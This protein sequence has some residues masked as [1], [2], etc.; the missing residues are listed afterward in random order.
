[1]RHRDTAPPDRLRATFRVD[2]RG[3]PPGLGGVV[4]QTHQIF[5]VDLRTQAPPPVVP[6][7]VRCVLQRSPNVIQAERTAGSSRFWSAS[8]ASRA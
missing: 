6:R 1:M 2:G 5:F 7:L 8:L 4:Q 3:G